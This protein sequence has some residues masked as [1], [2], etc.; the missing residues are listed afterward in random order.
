MEKK[1]LFI[2]MAKMAPEKQEAYNRWYNEERL[3]RVLERLPGILSG[4][5]FKVIEGEEE[6]QFLA[7][8][9]FESYEAVD[10]AL[11]SGAIRQLTREYEEAFGEGGE[12]GEGTAFLCVL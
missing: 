2:V 10:A 9:E 4:H 3:P 11:N 8:Y 7:L 1:G 6:Y 12:H 5:G